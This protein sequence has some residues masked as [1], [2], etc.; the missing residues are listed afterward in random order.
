M[1]AAIIPV[2]IRK[3]EFVSRVRSCSTLFQA[4]ATMQR[5]SMQSCGNTTREKSQITEAVHGMDNLPAESDLDN[6]S[7]RKVSLNV[8]L[9]MKHRNPKWEKFL[10][11]KGNLKANKFVKFEAYVHE[12]LKKPPPQPDSTPG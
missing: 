1:P 3:K 11:K 12:I 4:R 9:Q 5:S 8:C 7:L 10:T 2:I 6:D